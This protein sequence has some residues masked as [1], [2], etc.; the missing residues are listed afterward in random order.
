MSLLL[1]AMPF[2]PTSDGLFA[3]IK[4]GHLLRT[5]N[6][7]LDVPTQNH[8]IPHPARPFGGSVS[9]VYPGGSAGPI[10]NKAL[11]PHT[12]FSDKRRAEMRPDT[13]TCFT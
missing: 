4:A 3:L 8:R 11:R 7:L 5:S 9:C 6:I 13:A 12:Q 1:V 10:H 2:V